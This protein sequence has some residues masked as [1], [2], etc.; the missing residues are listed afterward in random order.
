M[1]LRK[2]ACRKFHATG[3]RARLGLG[4]PPRATPTPHPS[5][6]TRLTLLLSC[7]PTVRSCSPALP[8]PALPRP[9]FPRPALPR[10]AHPRPA[11]PH[12][13]RRAPR[14]SRPADPRPAHLPSRAP[15]SRAPLTRAPLSLTP[16]A[17][18]V[19]PSR[20]A[21][22]TPALPRHA[23]LHTHTH[24]GTTAGATAGLAA[25]TAPTQAAIAD[26]FCVRSSD[27][28][29]ARRT[30]ALAPSCW[31]PVRFG[32]FVRRPDLAA[33]FER[34]ASGKG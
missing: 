7:C 28:A 19:A 34:R 20:P 9:A 6:A 14:A 13:A 16:R 4:V 15:P 31:F 21:P 22:R 12:P 17:T 5:L 10:S 18:R 3:L 1:V 25:P 29:G 24:I 33:I 8:R 30:V 2:L 27:W 23:H 32:V 26:A 11:L